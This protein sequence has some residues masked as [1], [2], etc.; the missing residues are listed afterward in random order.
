[1]KDDRIVDALLKLNVGSRYEG[2]LAIAGQFG[3]SLEEAQHKIAKLQSENKVILVWPLAKAIDHTGKFHCNALP[4][5]SPFD[6]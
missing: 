1:M 6:D 4:G 5:R 2:A 3:L